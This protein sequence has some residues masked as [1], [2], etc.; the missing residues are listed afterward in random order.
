[1]MRRTAVHQIGS[2]GAVNND[3]IPIHQCERKNIRSA[4]WKVRKRGFTPVRIV[5]ALFILSILIFSLLPGNFSASQEL[6]T[7]IFVPHKQEALDPSMRKNSIQ[8]DNATI[9]VYGPTTL[10]ECGISN[11]DADPPSDKPVAAIA[12]G[13]LQIILHPNISPLACEGFLSLIRQQY[14]DGAFLFRVIPGFVAQWGYRPDFQWKADAKRYTRDEITD[15]VV[16]G[17][18]L[19]NTRG[20]LTF[21]G[22]ST[23]QVFVNLGD[24]SR[25]DQEG[26]RP[27]ATISDRSMKTVI[28]RLYMGYKGGSGQIP[29]IKEGEESVKKKFPKMSRIERCKVVQTFSQNYSNA[30]DT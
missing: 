7:E 14:F 16:P 30:F 24:N 18:S 17:R 1:M 22:G 26:G 27:F 29:T 9:S 8:T 13:V 28:D 4:D 23:V 5:T 12:K 3:I 19:S 11:L 10:V 20:T 6:T 2:S 21:A 15:S 25:L